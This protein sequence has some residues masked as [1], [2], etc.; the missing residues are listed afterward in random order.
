MADLDQMQTRLSLLF[1]LAQPGPRNE[2]AWQEFVDQYAPL[3]YGW[4]RRYNLQ[5]S[6]AK[7]VTQQ[8]ILKLAIHLPAFTYDPTKSFRAWLRTLSHHAWVDSLSERRKRNKLDTD[9]W[10]ELLTV[11][12][13]EDLLQKISE[14]FDLERLEQAMTRVRGRVQPATW[15]AFRLTAIEGVPATEVAQRLGKALASVYV[16]RSTVKKMLREEVEEL[17]SG[18]NS[19]PECGAAQV[20]QPKQP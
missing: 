13:R 9:A 19:K 12:A 11:E 14:E 10:N 6:D 20:S 4:C 18:T 3:I 5:D 17:E 15:D 7:D 1:R 8:V 2:R 16:A